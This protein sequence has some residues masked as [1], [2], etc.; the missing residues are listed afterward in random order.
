LISAPSGW[1]DFVGRNKP[2]LPTFRREALDHR[3][4]VS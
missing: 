3:L 4:D 2:V 1:S